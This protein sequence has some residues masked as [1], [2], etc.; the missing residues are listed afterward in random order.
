MPRI[1]CQTAVMFADVA[2]SSKLYKQVGD[3][4]A[5]QAVSRCID[6][7]IHEVEALKG[8][9]IKTI[10]DELMS[11]FESAEQA[12]SAAVAIQRSSRVDIEGLAIR[13]GIAYGSAILE[14]DDVF[15]QV[16]NDAAAVAH[17]ARGEQILITPLFAQDLQNSSNYTIHPY[18]RIKLKG[19]QVES[20]IYRVEWEPGEI[21]VDAT[22]YF[23]VDSLIER[24]TPT[25]EITYSDQS[26]Q[27][28][29][30][31]TPF[32]V[33]RDL[34]CSLVIQ[35]NFASRDHFHIVYRRGKFVLIDHSTNGTYVKIEETDPIYL[36]RE[37]L[38]LRETG[39]ISLGH[40][41]EA[42]SKQLV[43]YCA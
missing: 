33:G 1:T 9:A 4:Q 29:E 36:R 34:N 43:T 25:I 15:G 40:V 11:R 32:V 31:D 5:K 23:D 7:M 13:I 37:E 20:T 8:I 26:F 3:N 14:H 42:G 2:G 17:I 30:E 38:P 10:G 22:E 41:I 19:S 35:S 39:I 28:K 27:L 6:M 18:D 16:V 21:Q 24:I 12:C